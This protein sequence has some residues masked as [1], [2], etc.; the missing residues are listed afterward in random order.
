MFNGVKH[1]IIL[2][3]AKFLKPGKHMLESLL[4]TILSFKMKKYR[5]PSQK[6][7]DIKHINTSFEF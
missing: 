1:F 7:I 3:N 6:C 2:F 5:S 4:I